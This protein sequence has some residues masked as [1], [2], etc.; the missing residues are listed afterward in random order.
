MDKNQVHLEGTLYQEIEFKR[1]VKGTHVTKLTVV[2]KGRRKYGNEYID[3]LDPISVTTFGEYSAKHLKNLK[4]GD[5]VVVDGRIQISTY[6][7]KS[8]IQIIGEE[9]SSPEL[10][11]ET[12]KIEEAVKHQEVINPDDLP[13]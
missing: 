1:T 7:D 13:F 12:E 8:Y 10:K 9:V 4:I 3:T 2:I 6:K 5:R 11:S